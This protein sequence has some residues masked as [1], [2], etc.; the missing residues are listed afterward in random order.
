M[1]KL[2]RFL[3]S[4]CEKKV[5]ALKFS[6]VIKFMNALPRVSFRKSDFT[7]L[8][9]TLKSEVRWHQRRWAAPCT[10]Q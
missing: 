10:F 8:G 3:A 4:G 7:G 5:T 9:N 1:R 6:Q 2:L